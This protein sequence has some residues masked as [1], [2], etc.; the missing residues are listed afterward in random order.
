[1]AKDLSDHRVFRSL[2][3]CRTM[4]DAQVSGR[5]TLVVQGSRRATDVLWLVFDIDDGRLVS[6][7]GHLPDPGTQP[8]PRE[9]HIVIQAQ[10]GVWE[11]VSVDWPDTF[12]ELVRESRISILG[13]FRWYSRN[14]NILIQS[15]RALDI[16]ESIPEVSGVL[17]VG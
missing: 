15:L 1:M 7:T 8:P 16:W 6:I 5:I 3:S 14:L 11:R 4:G 2:M 13:D 12:I 10:L 17:E 9:D